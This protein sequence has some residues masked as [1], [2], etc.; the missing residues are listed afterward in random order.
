MTPGFRRMSGAD[1]IRALGNV[2]F[3]V[4]AT[5]GSHAK[6]RRVAPDGQRQ[7]LTIPL[8][9]SLA[10]GTAHAIFRQACRYVPEHQLRPFFF[11]GV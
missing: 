3:E 10:T 2:G 6:L 8:H 4:V 9:N 5:R 7:T 1:V 11:T